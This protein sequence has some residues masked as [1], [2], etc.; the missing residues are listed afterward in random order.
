MDIGAVCAGQSPPPRFVPCLLS[1]NNC[2]ALMNRPKNF[3]VY[4]LLAVL[5]IGGSR[6]PLCSQRPPPPR[7]HLHSPAPPRTTGR[8][9][10]LPPRVSRQP[11]APLPARPAPFRLPR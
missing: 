3:R 11:L 6:P 4:F 9:G 10:P 2:E 5:A 8:S 1:C 7:P